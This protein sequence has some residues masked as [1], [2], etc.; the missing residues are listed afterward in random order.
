MWQRR[1]CIAGLSPASGHITAPHSLGA[2]GAVG[3]I[4]QTMTVAPHQPS[5]D[6]RTMGSQMWLEVLTFTV[7]PTLN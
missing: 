5:A 7:P 6:P 1:H 2:R 3:T 4:G